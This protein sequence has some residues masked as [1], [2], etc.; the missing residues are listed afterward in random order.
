MRVISE[1]ELAKIL[2]KMEINYAQKM[3]KSFGDV[4][5]YNMNGVYAVREVRNKISKY[6]D[7]KYEK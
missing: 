2:N 1:Y 4:K 6:L 3:K 5:Q 7:K